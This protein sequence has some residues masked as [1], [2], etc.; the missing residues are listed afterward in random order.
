ML[1]GYTHALFYSELRWASCHVSAMLDGPNRALMCALTSIL[2][3]S[4][5][6]C[7]EIGRPAA[8]ARQLRTVLAAVTALERR[9]PALR[10]E[11]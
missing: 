1:V 7:L 3:G 10:G 2:P 6:V 11:L 8:P 9:C 5:L 4:A